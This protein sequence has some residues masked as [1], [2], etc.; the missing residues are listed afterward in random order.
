MEI[1]KVDN[2]VAAI[3]EGNKCIFFKIC[4]RNACKA[5]GGF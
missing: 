3:P 1:E 5:E 4:M 2:E